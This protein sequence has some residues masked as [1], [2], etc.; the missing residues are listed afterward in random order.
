MRSRWAPA[1]FC[2]QPPAHL[3]AFLH[4]TPCEIEQFMKNH[5]LSCAPLHVSTLLCLLHHSTSLCLLL[6]STLVCCSH[7][8]LP[9]AKN[10]CLQES[11]SHQARFQVR[12]LFHSPQQHHSTQPHPL[13]FKIMRC[14]EGET[15]R[16]SVQLFRWWQGFLGRRR[17]RQ[18]RLLQQARSWLMP[19]HCWFSPR[20]LS[21]L[22]H[23]TSIHAVFL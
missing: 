21:G 14:W 23:H 20:F 12:R 17:R 2:N 22:L 8:H 15:Y 5:P 11:K 7:R 3:E 6:H 10:H 9:K 13:L 18:W 16:A 1:H 19:C 4:T